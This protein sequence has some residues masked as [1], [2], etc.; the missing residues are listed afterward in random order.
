MPAMTTRQRL[1]NLLIAIGQISLALY[2]FAWPAWMVLR[3]LNDATLASARPAAQ[4]WEW[5]RALSRSIASWAQARRASTAAQTLKISDISGTEW[6]ASGAV[7]YLRATENLERDWQAQALHTPAAQ[8]PPRPSKYARGAIDAAAALIADPSNASWVQR[9]WGDDYLQRENVFYRMLVIDGLATYRLLTG[10]SRYSALLAAQASSLSAELDASEF[11]LLDDYP[12][13][14]YPTDIIAAWR[15]VQR[16]DVALGSDHSAR[17]ARGLRAFIGR[18]QSPE[19]QL[20]PSAIDRHDLAYQDAVRGSFTTGMLHHSAY[21]WPEQSARWY[22]RFSEHFYRAGWLMTGFREYPELIAPE[23]F[24]DVD[25]G[26]V[27]AGLGTS[28]S[29]FGVSAARAHGRFDHARPIALE[30]VAMA[31]PLPSGTLLLARA[32]SDAS[33][34]PFIGEAAIL[35]TLT[36]PV[37]PAFVAQTRPAGNAL[38]GLVLVMLLMYVS[39][40]AWLLRCAWRRLARLVILPGAA[41]R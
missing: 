25:A 2:F 16:A 33:D 15:A 26:P 22:A 36:Q 7:F 28:A 39:V 17:I 13:Q 20:P 6:P 29:A 4:S 8:L 19:H 10:D 24:L 5:H 32:V 31:W 18:A 21:L 23:N 38:P 9:H 35:M 41:F 12:N 14:C 3:A 11:G 30:M 40:A 34:A 27:I 37:A 1:K